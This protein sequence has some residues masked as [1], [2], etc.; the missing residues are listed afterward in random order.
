MG[1][2]A[3][4]VLRDPG[5]RQS[6]ILR[7]IPR[8]GSTRK[9]VVTRMNRFSVP[10]IGL[11]SVPTGCLLRAAQVA[12]LRGS[13]GNRIENRGHIARRH[14]ACHAVFALKRVLDA[15]PV[16]Q[17]FDPAGIRKCLEI[18]ERIRRLAVDIRVGLHKDS[19][20]IELGQQHRRIDDRPRGAWFDHHEQRGDIVGIQPDASV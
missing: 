2:G 9:W 12:M 11:L 7:A 17:I 16:H 20:I 18:V 19:A 8:A 1:T 10:A 14:I 15:L 6:G 5:R 4:R 13:S 3:G